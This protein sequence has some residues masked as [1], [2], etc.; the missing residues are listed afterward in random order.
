MLQNAIKKNNIPNP[1]INRN[2]P[3]NNWFE[4]RECGA[5]TKLMSNFKDGSILELALW[6]RKEICQPSLKVTRSVVLEFSWYTTSINLF[7]SFNL[8][9]FAFGFIFSNGKFKVP[10]KL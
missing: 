4:K 2:H 1:N 6:I 3:I 10:C 8:W 7:G 9:I 5:E